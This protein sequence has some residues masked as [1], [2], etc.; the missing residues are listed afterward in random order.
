MNPNDNQSEFP[1]NYQVYLLRL[2]REAES[3]KWVI[4]LQYAQES[5][6]RVFADLESLV[7]FLS[8][9]MST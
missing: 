5:K 4:S 8:K 3:E 2:Q 6:Q 9:Q 1:S 7:L